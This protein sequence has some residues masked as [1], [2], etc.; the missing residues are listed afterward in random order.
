MGAALDDVTNEHI[1]PT[2]IR[3]RIEDWKDRLNAL[4]DQI[5]GFLP[6]GWEAR[7]GIPLEMNEQMM[8]NHGIKPKSLPTLDLVGE[9]GRIA[10]VTPR[11]LWIIGAN[12]RVDL[13]YGDRHYL[14]VDMAGR[15]AP[16]DWQAMCARHRRETRQTVTPGWLAEILR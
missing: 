6:E 1:N 16:P 8:R 15:F 10:R 4:Y 13:K 9:G 7:S 3:K 5:K 2:E 11:G 14:I 12:G